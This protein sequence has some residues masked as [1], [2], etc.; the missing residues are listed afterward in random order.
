[1][2][3]PHVDQIS[4]KPVGDH[5]SSTPRNHCAYPYEEG[6]ASS[7]MAMETGW[8]LLAFP[9]LS[10]GCG[11]LWVVGCGLWMWM[12]LWL[13]RFI[14]AGNLTQLAGRSLSSVRKSSAVDSP[15]SYT[16]LPEGVHQPP[17]T[18]THC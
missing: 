2:T 10:C 9:L 16:S 7:S 11:W 14:L 17:H 15:A 3:H 18:Q 12:S 6:L 4:P 8:L 5:G 1:M 13:E